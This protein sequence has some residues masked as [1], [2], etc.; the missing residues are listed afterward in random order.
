MTAWFDK[1]YMNLKYGIVLCLIAPV[2][3]PTANGAKPRHPKVAVTTAKQDVVINEIRLTVAI[4][5]P[6]V[7]RLSAEV[8][9]LIQ[10][11]H[12]EEGDAVQAG[13]VL[14]TLDNAM[15]ALSLQ[16][17]KASTQ[18]AQAE[19]DDA[20]LRLADGKQLAKKKTLSENDLETLKAEVNIADATLQRY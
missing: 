12:V 15:V 20:K 3:M 2:C 6:R 10:H 5:S 4:S 8:S 16:V 18:R 13:D 19:L 11:V 17:A 1:Y 9:G 14:V 7:S